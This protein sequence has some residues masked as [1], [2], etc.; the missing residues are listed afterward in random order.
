MK[1]STIYVKNKEMV[2][3]SIALKI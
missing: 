2:A 3:Y 1:I